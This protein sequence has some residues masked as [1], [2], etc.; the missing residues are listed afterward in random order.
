MNEREKLL[1]FISEVS[2]ALLDCAMFL[3][4]H[5]DNKEALEYYHKYRCMREEAMK[6][7]ES[8]FGPLL[9]TNVNSEN[10]WTWVC[11]KWP[12]EGGC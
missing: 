4:T 10:E 1:M 8:C 2:F 6:E 9:N 12:W 7:Y 5:P 11:G 3:D